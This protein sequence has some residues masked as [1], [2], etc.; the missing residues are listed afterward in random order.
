MQEVRLADQDVEAVRIDD[1]GTVG[2]GDQESHELSGPVRLAEPRADRDQAGR[3]GHAFQDGPGASEVDQTLLVGG[4]GIG[5]VAGLEARDD[6]LDLGG[7]GD[8][9]QPRAGTERG[10]AAECGRAGH[11]PSAGHHQDRAYIPLLLSLGRGESL[12][13]VSIDCRAMNGLAPPVFRH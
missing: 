2:L 5:H 13:R 11:P 7:G 4:E 6:R 10:R 8:A 12:E 3:G 9:D 1:E